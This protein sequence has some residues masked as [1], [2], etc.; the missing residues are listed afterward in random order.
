MAD[1]RTVELSREDVDAFL[2]AGGT[3]V[4][5]FPGDPPHSLP[6]SYGYDAQEGWFYFRLAYQPDSQKPDYDAGTV[7]FVTYD[8]TEDGWQSV[9]ATGDLQPVEE[10]DVPSDVLAGLQRVDIPLVDIFEKPV[11]ETTF[12]FFVLD[13]DAVS[14]RREAPDAG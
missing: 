7:S 4:I 1:T 2:G 9:V 6:V 5:S 8:E 11:R 3:G 10:A 12:G 13:P 14:G